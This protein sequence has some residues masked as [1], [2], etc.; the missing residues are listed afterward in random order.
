MEVLMAMLRG[1]GMFLV[2]KILPTV[3]SRQNMLCVS[4]MSMHWDIDDLTGKLDERNYTYDHAVAENIRAMGHHFTSNEF[5]NLLGFKNYEDMDIDAVDGASIM[6]DLNT[7]VPEELHKRFDFVVENGTLEHIFDIKTAISNIAQMVSVGGVVSH[8]SPLDALNHGFYNFSIN[9]F[10]DFYRANGFTDME[11][12]IVRYSSKWRKNQSV[13]VVNQAY[14][15]DEFSFNPDIYKTDMDKAYI[16]CRATKVEHVAEIRS[17]I[18]A[19]YDRD[20]KISSRL[21]DW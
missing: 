9:F 21:N 16:A 4:R 5:F 10:N 11:F 2:D 1:Y 17:P 7:P 8:G 6:H 19:A 14:T 12:Y 20:L 13:Y 18:Q 3:P 15:H